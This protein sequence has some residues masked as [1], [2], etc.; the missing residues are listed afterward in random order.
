MLK[1]ESNGNANCVFFVCHGN[2]F[3]WMGRVLSSP[4][5]ELTKDQSNIKTS[6]V[7]WF[8]ISLLETVQFDKNVSRKP[9]TW[10]GGFSSDISETW[11]VYCLLGTAHIPRKVLCLVSRMCRGDREVASPFPLQIFIYT[12]EKMIFHAWTKNLGLDMKIAY[13]FT[14]YIFFGVTAITYLFWLFVSCLIIWQ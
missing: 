10:W 9:T 4:V 6:Y 5:S 8:N 13:T 1:G 3:H 11:G 2:M 14:S 12:K 7:C